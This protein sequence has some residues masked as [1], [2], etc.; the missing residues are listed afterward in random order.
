MFKK[1]MRLMLL[2]TVASVLIACGGGGGSGL[3]PLSISGTAAVGAPLAGATVKVYDATGALVVSDGV[4]QANGNYSLTIPAGKYGPFIFVVDDTDQ[5]FISVLNDVSQT[6]VNITPLSNLLAASLSA[7]GNPANLVSEIAN[8]SAEINS[9]NYNA[10]VA[11]IRTA[12]NS[13][14]S[15]AGVTVSTFDPVST[16]FTTNGTGIDKVLDVLD[17]SITP[18]STTS[19]NVELTVKIS[20]NED[21]VNPDNSLKFN[22][23]AASMGTLPALTSSDLPPDGTSVLIQDLLDKLTACFAIPLANRI[24]ANG[25]AATDIT[26]QACKDVFINS[27]PSQ[28]LSSGSTISKTGHFGGIFTATVPVKFDRP[29]FFGAVRTSQT[30]GPVAGDLLI[31]YRW[32]DENGNF[33]YERAMV[34]KT[35]A[36]PAKFEIVGNRYLYESAV[37]PYAQLRQFIRDNDRDYYSVGYSPY[38][39]RR[40]YPATGGG[41]KSISRVKVTTPTGREILL[42]NDSN[43]SFLVMAKPAV[44]PTCATSNDRTG[45][46]FIRLRSE[47]ANKSTTTS[48]HPR[49]KDTTVAFVGTDWT[50]DEIEAVK[51][52]SAWKYEYT[53][54][55]SSTAVQWHRPP[56]RVHSLREFKKVALPTVTPTVLTNMKA[57]VQATIESTGSSVILIPADGVQ[58]SWVKAYA[59][60]NNMAP[61]D[62]VPMTA[63]R[64]FGRYNNNGVT[65]SFEDRMVVRSNNTQATIKCPSASEAQ[66]ASLY[67]Y[68]SS[69]TQRSGYSGLDLWSRG[70]DGVEYVNFYATYMID[71]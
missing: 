8:R 67:Q 3:G 68:R 55:D 51:T 9:T 5:Q 48:N 69:A 34:R 45:T 24:T 20:L 62:A 65:S 66:C 15:A 10:K 54:S 70:P 59:S 23:T 56:R 11:S 41:T 40:L 18:S 13:V 26:A 31:G 42:C 52:Y 64:I 17:V 6:T 35:T 57:D 49:N 4:V 43:Y 46:S 28:Y 7:S 1:T 27:D 63:I 53:F 39:A 12:I 16:P 71:P 47:Y 50:D 58:V 22:S 19:S 60:A 37:T 38:V 14:L 32:K 36:T 44:T 30:N 29:K 2:P 33:Q 25:T 21:D 61:E